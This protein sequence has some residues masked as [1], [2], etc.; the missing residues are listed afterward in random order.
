MGSGSGH[1]TVPAKVAMRANG[2]GYVAG[3]TTGSDVAILTSRNTLQTAVSNNLNET[4]SANNN[5]FRISP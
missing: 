5:T 1:M 2:F 4:E 3:T